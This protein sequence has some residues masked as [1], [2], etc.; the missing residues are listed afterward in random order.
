MDWRSGLN[1]L[2]H[3]GL[4]S[5]S[6][7]LA[8]SLECNTRQAESIHRLHA[9]FTSDRIRKPLSSQSQAQAHEIGGGYVR[10]VLALC[11]SPSGSLSRSLWLAMEVV[12]A[13]QSCFH[14]VRGPSV[15]SHHASL[16]APGLSEDIQGSPGHWFVRFRL[17]SVLLRHFHSA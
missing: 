11:G 2:C 17:R 10:G 14:Y 6:G 16:A 9:A 1:M 13:R 4:Q 3:A 12:L 7:L 5:H 15:R 8:H